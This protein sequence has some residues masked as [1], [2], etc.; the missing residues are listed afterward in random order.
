MCVFSMGD[1]RQVQEEQ[2]SSLKPIEV[3][4]SANLKVGMSVFA[5]GNP[6]GLDHTMTSGI[7]S[8]L[9]RVIQGTPP[10]PFPL[11]HTHTHTHT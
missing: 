3:G 6:F 4:K 11:Q 9:G 10:Q 2:A 5:I 1:S 7:I 8:G